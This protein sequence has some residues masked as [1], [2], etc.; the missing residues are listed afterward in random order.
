[1]GSG[2]TQGCISLGSGRRTGLVATDSTLG[3]RK[4]RR[5]GSLL[6]VVVAGG[7]GTGVGKGKIWEGA[8]QDY[9]HCRTLLIIRRRPGF[10]MSVIR[11]CC[12]WGGIPHRALYLRLFRIMMRRARKREVKKKDV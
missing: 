9:A 11:D 8:V 3:S 5:G 4:S 2:M 12:Q 10:L 1:M 6:A 7:G